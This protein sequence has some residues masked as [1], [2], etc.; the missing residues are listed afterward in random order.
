MGKT[1]AL[2][3]SKLA[4]AML[5]ARRNHGYGSVTNG[6]QASSS[7]LS[8]CSEHEFN[9]LPEIPLLTYNEEVNSIVYIWHHLIY[10]YKS[11]ICAYILWPLPTA[12][13]ILYF[14]F[15]RMMR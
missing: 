8:T 14:Y 6:S 5:F 9:Q 11:E 15:Y 1:D 2:D 10:D 13:I 7:G 3:P 4:A 12:C